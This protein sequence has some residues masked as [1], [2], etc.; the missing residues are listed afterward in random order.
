MITP[1]F[2]VF[3]RD[4]LLP[5]EHSNFYNLDKTSSIIRIIC[6]AIALTCADRRGR[7]KYQIL[8]LDRHTGHY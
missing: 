5:L 2:T 8:V 4:K 1:S 3:K 7:E 6:P